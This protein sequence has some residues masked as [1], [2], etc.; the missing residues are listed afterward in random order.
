MYD[1]AIV[2]GGT[3]G[4]SAATFTGRA[5][6]QTVVI[7]GDKGMTRRAMLY[8]HLGFP[9]GITGPELVDKG[10]EQAEKAGATWMKADVTGLEK[11]D[12]GFV[13]TTEGGETVEAREVLLTLG[14]NLA[15]AKAAG[16]ETKAGTEPRIAEVIAVDGEGLFALPQEAGRELLTTAF[17][18]AADLA[19][20][21]SLVLVFLLFLLVSTKE[22]AGIR[23]LGDCRKGGADEPSRSF[24]RTSREAARTRGH[25]GR[26]GGSWL[27]TNTLTTRP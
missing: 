4:A 6:L 17:S 24:G 12:D 25:A 2:G 3:A 1:L 10:Q 13:L 20:K 26:G 14:G 18:G 8:N 23:H 16:I 5:G 21:G 19:S 9:E 27:S 22:V 11:R 7:D 15:L